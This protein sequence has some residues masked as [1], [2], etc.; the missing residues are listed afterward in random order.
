MGDPT[1]IGPEVTLAALRRPAVRRRLQPILVGDIG[2]YADVARQLRLPV[3]F[4]AWEPGQALP[5]GAVAVREVAAVPR[6]QRRPGRPTLAGGRAAHAAILEALRLVR[7]GAA[8]ALTTAPICKAN[9]VAAGRAVSGHTELLAALCGDVPVRMMMIGGRLRV[10]L[11]TT[12]LA[13]RA[14]PDAFDAADVLTTVRIA[15]RALRER[16]RIRRPRLGVAGLNPHAGE[17]GVF[18]DE[19]LRVIAPAVRRARR[20]GIDARGPLAA[21]S[22]FPLAYTGHFDA[23]VCMYHDQGLAPFKLV[24]F[25]DG[26]NFTAGLPVVRTSPDHGTAHDIAGRGRADASSMTAALC[27]AA[28]LATRPASRQPSMR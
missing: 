28:E 11:V 18:G 5:R 23:V 17:Q 6:A 8:D 21:D 16:F 7:T 27:M 24:H 12:H 10:A 22:L 25:A 20:L 13:L 15:E 3:R 9:L 19:D 4:A 14:V 26:V 2:V 1:G